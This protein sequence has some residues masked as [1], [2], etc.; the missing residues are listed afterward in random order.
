MDIIVA[1][2][3]STIVDADCILVLNK[4]KIIDSGTHKELMERCKE[5]RK[6]YRV[7]GCTNGYE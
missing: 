6:L 2:R 1:H 3:L 5:Y 7:E 4:H